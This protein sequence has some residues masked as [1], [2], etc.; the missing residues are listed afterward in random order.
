MIDY[1]TKL[2]AVVDWLT[3]AR[4][5]YH[6][7]LAGPKQ[8]Y[9]FR[10]QFAAFRKAL[11]AA[12]RPWTLNWQD[13][14][15]HLLDATAITGFEAHYIYHCAWAARVL[16]ETRP[17]THVDISSHLPFATIVSAFLPVQFYDYQPA[18]LILSGLKTGQADLCALNFAD[19]SIGSL[20]CMH[21]VEHI[22]LGRYGDPLNPNGDLQA[23]AELKRVLAPGGS[24]LF[25]VPIGKPKIIFNAHRI[26]SYRQI[27]DYFAELELKQ[28]ALIPDAEKIIIYDARE[29]LADAQNYGCGCFWFRKA[30]Q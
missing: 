18:P 9:T 13:R 4:Q 17:N 7:E 8:Y 21:V 5:S 11:Q 12:G 22:G 15:A 10:R 24:L 26:Y 29:E 16:A 23:I 25:V 27:R 14:Q 1:P 30:N 2:K 20:S 3:A 6:R 28:F 19:R